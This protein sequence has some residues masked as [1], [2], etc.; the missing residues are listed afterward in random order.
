MSDYS[1]VLLRPFIASV[2]PNL[3]SWV[4]RGLTISQLDELTEV[5]SDWTICQ[6][7]G[8]TWKLGEETVG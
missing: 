2:I 6:L 3:G 1:L 4:E 8:L 5:D 7:D